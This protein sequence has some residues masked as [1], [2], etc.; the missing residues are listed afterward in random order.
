MRYFRPIL[1]TA[2]LLCIPTF[3][4]TAQ[5]SAVEYVN[6]FIGTGAHGHTYPGAT[7]PFGMVQLSPDAGKKGWDWCS[8]YHYSDTALIGFS[9]THLSG[10][11]CADLGDIL[12]M[13]TTSWRSVDRTYRSPFSHDREEASPGY[14]KV[15]LLDNDILVE[16]TTTRRCGLHRYTFPVSDSAR[17]IVDLGYGQDDR[18]VE[19]GMRMVD[20]RLLTGY[21]VSSGWAPLQRVYFAAQF[22]APVLAVT[23]GEDGRRVSSSHEFS[24]RSALAVLSFGRAATQHPLLV[25]VGISSVSVEN[26]LENLRAEADYFDDFDQA[27]WQARRQWDDALSQISFAAEDDAM[28]RTFTTALYHC[29]LAPALYS[30]T[31]GRY[32]GGDDSVHSAEGYEHYTIFSL[33]D[34]FRALHPL[35]TIL[36]PGLVTHWVRSMLAF[37]DESGQLPVWTLHANETNCMIGYHSVPVIADALLKGIEGIDANKALK[38]MKA[39]AEQEKG[40]LKF[41]S[42]A[43]ELDVD[44]VLSNNNRRTLLSTLDWTGITTVIS[45]FASEESGA[46]LGYHS[47]HPDAHEA[48]LTRATYEAMPIVWRSAVVPAEAGDGAIAL[49]WLAGMS[50]NKGGNLFTLSVNGREILSF[51]T[52]RTADSSVVTAQGNGA[53]LHFAADMVDEFGDL[54]GTMTLILP[55]GMFD[56]GRPLSLRLEGERAGSQDWVMTFKHSFSGRRFAATDVGSAQGKDGP[57]QFARVCMEHLGQP[58]MITVTSDAGITATSTL[59]PGLNIITTPMKATREERAAHLEVRDD[60]GRNETIRF[61]LRPQSTPRYIPADKENESVSKTL[62]YAYDDW[63]I[64]QTATLLGQHADAQRFTDRS[65]YY[66]SLFDTDLGFMRGRNL[67]GSWRTPFNPRF[68]TLKQHEYTEGNAWQYTWFVPHDVDGLIGLMGGREKFCAKLDSLFE[69]SSDLEGTGATGDVTGLIGMY[70]HG[71]EPSHHIAYLYNRAGQPW[72]TQRLVRRIMREMYHDQPD[73]L[74]GNEDCGQMSAWYVFSAMGFYPVNPCG[75]VYDIGSPVLDRVIIDVGDDKVF[76]IEAENNTPENV[77]IQAA[78]LNGNPL[79]H[80]WIRHEDIMRGGTLHF[81]MGPQPSSL[82]STQQ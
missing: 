23:N 61:T 72:K 13:P 3:F 11:G 33:W 78:T 51:R 6:P 36:N 18:T 75:G 58:T 8:G 73:G 39:S 28:R 42:M 15:R 14:Y 57:L 32:R 45:G 66:R 31:D 9:H 46:T 79:E 12:F 49:A 5:S 2:S 22:S 53:V 63:C 43:S 19:S 26:A 21:R 50:T 7:V 64:A 76:T 67:D 80:P 71:N 62:E 20:D 4:L 74:I 34:T 48:L 35:F 25:K 44:S 40:G 17:I 27:R 68:S 70:A 56:S 54:F 77:Y 37:Y 16:L 41:Y 29:M 82:W 10:T 81:V 52:P 38:A 24:G 1:I 30:D 59:Y 60:A 55:K 47:S 69:Q 65:Q